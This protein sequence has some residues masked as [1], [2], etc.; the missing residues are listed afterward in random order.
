MT[1]SIPRSRAWLV[2]ALLV[3]ACSHDPVAR[4]ASYVTSGDGYT[5][6]QQ[7]ARAILEYRN[8]IK[9]RPDWAE[10][11]YKL[12]RAYE[13]SGDPIKAYGE[14]SRTADLEPANVDAQL[15]AGNLLL[16]AGEFDRARTRAELALKTAPNSAPA[17]ILLG[18]ALAG[19]NETAK[20]VKQ[21]EQAL[22]LDPSYAPAWSALGAAQFAGGSR[23]QAGA[24][25]AKA[26]EL[27]PRSIDA[28]L[29]LANYHWAKGD[30]QHAE[31]ALTQALAIE[32]SNA[33]VHRALALFYLA[34]RRAAEAEPHFKALAAQPGGE[35]ALAD[36][37]S[38]IDRR[39][40][41]LKVLHRIEAGSDKS[42]SRAA[43]LRIA[44]L[45]YSAGH[46]AEAHKL[47]DAV[48]AEKPRNVDARLAKARMLLGDGKADE[49]AVHAKEAVKLEPE[50]PASQY[51]LG[52]TA[53]AR[54]DTTGAEQAFQEV[55]KINPRAAVASLPD[56][57]TAPGARRNRRR[58]SCRGGSVPRASGRRGS[59]GV[60]VAEPPCAGGR[61]ARA[62]GTERPDSAAT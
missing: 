25:F 14:Y 13:A 48:I 55:L 40:D 54:N 5:A 38:G 3:G 42:D 61:A 18:N 39:D 50:S 7:F 53:M 28:R 22:A 51:T 36:Y 31:Q 44:T 57:E 46:K 43:R 23:E 1:R 27:A 2:V 4:S 52:L 34:T 16:S 6:K 21:I 47:V 32:S 26:V 35:L 56:R 8:A 62:A 15:K 20:A 10:P 60:A 59:R 30:V 33:A 24:A 29:A 41:A 11:H 17:N 19:L 45:E 58:G 12:A 37:Y 9:E 49:A